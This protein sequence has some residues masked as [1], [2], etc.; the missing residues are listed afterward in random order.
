[1]GRHR[2]ESI[3]GCHTRE[4]KQAWKNGERKNTNAAAWRA[5]SQFRERGF[6]FQ[7]CHGTQQTPLL[8]AALEAVIAGGQPG[9]AEHGQKTQK[10][11]TK[12]EQK[13]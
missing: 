10:T 1:M 11:R 9:R 3:A 13:G 4:Q 12:R 7:S 5:L 2:A 6:G 8:I